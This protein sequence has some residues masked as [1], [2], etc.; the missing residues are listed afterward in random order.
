MKHRPGP[1]A[2]SATYV[3]A[4]WTRPRH[5][6]STTVASSA[7]G[8]ARRYPCRIARCRRSVAAG[9]HGRSDDGCWL[10]GCQRASPWRGEK[11]RGRQEERRHRRRAF[12]PGLLRSLC[13][14]ASF[15][16]PMAGAPSYT[17]STCVSAR[18]WSIPYVRG[19]RAQLRL[20]GDTSRR[21]A[22][23]RRCSA[24]RL[25]SRASSGSHV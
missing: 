24:A 23:Q 19:A 21:W 20:P 16:M 1:D 17:A 11:P 12:P 25:T 5:G 3:R 7:Q 22:K 18:G 10:A 6:T 15:V 4:P 13:R 8:E 2:E 9:S 14:T